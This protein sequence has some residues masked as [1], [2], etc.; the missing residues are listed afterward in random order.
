MAAWL[1]SS[2]RVGST[3]NDGRS[4]AMLGNYDTRFE[5]AIAS[6]TTIMTAP[7]DI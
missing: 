7:T 4:L 2:P 6:A 3:R 5:T 1:V